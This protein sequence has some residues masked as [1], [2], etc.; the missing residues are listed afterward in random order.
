MWTTDFWKAVA[1]RAV[2]T[3]VQTLAA[4]LTVVVAQQGGFT[5]VAWAAAL[6]A[7]GLATVLSV[8]TSVGS[9]AATDG[10]PS[11]ASESLPDEGYTEGLPEDD[12]W[13]LGISHW[14]ER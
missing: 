5:D 11:L 13:E 4:S 6:S 8:L 3:F 2:K 9:A 14:T 7:A 1:E 10:G 12:P